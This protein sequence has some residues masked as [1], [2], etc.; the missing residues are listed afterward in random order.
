MSIDPQAT[1]FACAI[2]RCP[3]GSFPFI[4][5]GLPIKLTSLCQQDW[6]PLLD[7]FDKRLATWKGPCLS[8]GGRLMLLNATLSSLL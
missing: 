2:L 4:S 1:H 3:L 5:L 6:Q 7:K 8:R